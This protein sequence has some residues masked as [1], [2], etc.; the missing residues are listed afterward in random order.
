MS[1]DERERLEEIEA[2]VLVWST[3]TNAQ[4]RRDA[5]SAI[6]L[7]KREAKRAD[8]FAPSLAQAAQLSR[9]LANELLHRETLERRLATAEAK[10][11]E[12]LT[13]IGCDHKNIEELIR[14]RDEVERERDEARKLLHAV[15]TRC[16]PAGDARRIASYSRG[17]K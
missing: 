1:P 14:Q 17:R 5:L 13:Q 4:R 10:Y 15:E 7:A 2:R 12:R 9:D 11:K 8:E 6:A 16:D 3:E